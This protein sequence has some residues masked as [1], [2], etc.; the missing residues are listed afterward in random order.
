MT[1]TQ[2]RTRPPVAKVGGVVWKLIKF[3]PRRYSLVLIVLGAWWSFPILV[4]L[5]MQTVVDA[6]AGDAQTEFSIPALFGI[7]VAVETLRQVFFVSGLML[8]IPWWV[9]AETLMRTNMLAAQLASGGREAGPPVRHAGAGVAVLR[10]DVEDVLELLDNWLD[11]AGITAFTAMALTIMATIDLRVTLVVVI[12]LLLA[13]FV[14]RGLTMRLQEYRRAD[15]EATSAVT[16]LLGNLFSA[17][18]AVKV[19][20]AEPCAGRRLRQLNATRLRTA[21]RDKVLAQLLEAFNSSTVE[22]S[23]GLVLLFTA[24][25]MRSGDFT[26]GDLAL[27]ATYVG[28]LAM[29]PRMVGSLLMRHKHGQVAAGRMRKLVPGGNPNIVATHRALRM[30]IRGDQ[31]MPVQPRPSAPA[32]AGVA[33]HDLEHRFADGA[34][35]L[36]AVN[37][38]LEPGSFTVVC[39]PVGSGKTTLLRTLMGLADRAPDG[40]ADDHSEQ[41]T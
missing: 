15:R 2:S 5:G 3:D 9:R 30:R 4:G 38:T 33:V 8:F 19:A 26:V 37:L 17:V 18:L 36:E 21:L 22:V 39:G 11:L 32:A 34:V 16:G 25:A 12:P 23:V 40:G 27:F 7:L 20:G 1:A 10:N 41:L 31:P 35:G 14:T 24:P 28:W 6:I 29:F 13:I